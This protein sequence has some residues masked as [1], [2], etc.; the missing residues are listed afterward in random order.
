MLLDTFVV[1]TLAV[2]ALLG[3]TDTK[4]WWPKTMPP[5]TRALHDS[6][7]DNNNIGGTAY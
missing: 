5:V 4:S 1:R 6:G 7:G 2:P 3:L